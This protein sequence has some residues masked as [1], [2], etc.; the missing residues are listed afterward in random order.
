MGIPR[1]LRPVST[2]SATGGRTT[3]RNEVSRPSISPRSPARRLQACDLCRKPV[4]LVSELRQVVVLMRLFSTD[5]VD[6]DGSSVTCVKSLS[7]GSATY[8][9]DRRS[10]RDPCSCVSFMPDALIY[11]HAPSY[12]AGHHRW[13]MRAFTM[14]ALRFNFRTLC[15]NAA[16]RLVRSS[17]SSHAAAS[18]NEPRNA[19]SKPFSSP[20]A[21]PS[22]RR[23]MIAIPSCS[24]GPVE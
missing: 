5:S 10:V 21:K 7:C 12:D 14:Q 6:K 3:T 22:P 19:N 9:C 11:A 17:V 24:Y 13:I 1:R 15:R 18:T 20:S 2:C 23:F 4:S 8:A 16:E